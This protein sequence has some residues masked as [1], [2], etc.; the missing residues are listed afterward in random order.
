MN[1]AAGM[2]PVRLRREF[3]REVRLIGGF[4]KRIVAQGPSAIVA[5]FTRLRPTIE[6]GGFMPAIDHSVSSDIS[7]DNY[8]HY[9]DALCKALNLA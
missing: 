8:R 7:W 1:P 6:E 9:L 5:E 3:G 4:D 2:D